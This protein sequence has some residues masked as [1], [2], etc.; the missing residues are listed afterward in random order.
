MGNKVSADVGAIG[1]LAPHAELFGF[2]SGAWVLGADATELSLF[3]LGHCSGPKI[4]LCDACSNP[5]L[6]E[7]TQSHTGTHSR[8]HVNFCRRVS[9]DCIVSL[10][11]PVTVGRPNCLN[12]RV[13]AE[14]LAQDLM[15]N[16]E[17]ERRQ[18]KPTEDLLLLATFSACLR[19]PLQAT[20]VSLDFDPHEQYLQSDSVLRDASRGSRLVSVRGHRPLLCVL[21]FGERWGAVRRQGP[22]AHCSSSARLPRIRY[23]LLAGSV[24]KIRGGPPNS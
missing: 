23:L 10:K 6:W 14:C 21:H 3:P 18:R 7:S 16:E 20:S 5:C 4:N 9:L 2:G 8:R 12:F 1:R 11:C 17:R 15:K 19:I 24:L 13:V 22:R